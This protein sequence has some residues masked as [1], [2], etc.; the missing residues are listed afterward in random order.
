MFFTKYPNLK[1]NWRGGGGGGGRK[2]GGG[3]AAGKGA[4]VSDIFSLRI[5]I[6]NKKN[7]FLFF[8][9]VGGGGGELGGGDGGLL[10]DVGISEFYFTMNPN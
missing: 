8:F 3:G 4:G 5:Q 6:S 2:G 7:I 10:R 9:L 1:K